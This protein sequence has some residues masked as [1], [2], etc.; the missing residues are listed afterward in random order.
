MSI[1][2]RPTRLPTPPGLE[3]RGPYTPAVRAGDFVFLSGQIGLSPE[4]GRLADGGVQ[5]QARQTLSNITAILTAAGL[6][7]HDMASPR[8][9]RPRH[10]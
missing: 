5:A 7:V 6:T 4:T 9:P 2:P 10:P 1:E 3:P 8:L